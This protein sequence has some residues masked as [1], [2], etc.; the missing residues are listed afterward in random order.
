MRRRPAKSRND[1]ER[2]LPLINVVFL[3]LIFFMLTGRLSTPDQFETEP[4]ASS[5]RTSVPQLRIEVI[6]ALDGRLA[7]EGKAVTEPEFIG[8]VRKS[9]AEAGTSEVR[10]K[11]DGQIPAARV[12]EILDN[13]GK[14]GVEKLYLVT[15]ERDR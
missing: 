5:S 8:A 9:L 6:A 11:A 4:P 2:V 7:I 12:I 1:D 13:L 15:A 14:A 10:F 3:L